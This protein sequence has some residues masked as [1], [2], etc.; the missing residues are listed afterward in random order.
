MNKL[1][2]KTIKILTNKGYN[3]SDYSQGNL[4]DEYPC[5]YIT[6]DDWYILGKIKSYKRVRFP[7]DFTNVSKTLL[8]YHNFNATQENI[9]KACKSLEKWANRLPDVNFIEEYNKKLH[10][11]KEELIKYEIFDFVTTDEIKE[12]LKADTLRLINR[13]ELSNIK[14]ELKKLNVKGYSKLYKDNAVKLLTEELLK[15]DL[16]TILDFYETNK[17]KLGMFKKEVLE[18]LDMTDYAFNKIRNNFKIAGSIRMTMDFKTLT[19]DMYDRKY[20]YN[21]KFNKEV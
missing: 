10:C 12:I 8:K 3:I 7:N 15:Q 17:V 6:F 1:L 4:S 2:S 13:V 9:E 19:V 18:T 11:K 5:T 21:Y 14:A 16:N 20:V